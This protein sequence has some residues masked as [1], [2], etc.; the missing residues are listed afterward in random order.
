MTQASTILRAII[1]EIAAVNFS[2]VADSPIDRILKKVFILDLPGV[3]VQL[4][5]S[6]G[7]RFIPHFFLC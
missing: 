3:E 6:V 2:S 5:S 7:A 1:C 4:Y